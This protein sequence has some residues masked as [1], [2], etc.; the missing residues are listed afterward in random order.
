MCQN[1]SFNPNSFTREERKKPIWKTYAKIKHCSIE[2][3]NDAWKLCKYVQ[4]TLK[5]EK[6]SLKNYFTGEKLP[7][8][9]YELSDLDVKRFL[10]NNWTIIKFCSHVINKMSR[11]RNYMIFYIFL[12]MCI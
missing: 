7:V 5:F 3:Q 12:L 8:I 10:W 2:N 1:L 6:L 9:I 11:N 4:L